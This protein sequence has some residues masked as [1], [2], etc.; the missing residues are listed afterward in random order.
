MQDQF[1]FLS[2]YEF[3]V[4]HQLLGTLFVKTRDTMCLCQ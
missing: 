1:G 3:K 4:H 2:F